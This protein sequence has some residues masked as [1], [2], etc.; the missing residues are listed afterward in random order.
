MKYVPAFVAALA[1]AFLAVVLSL[2]TQAQVQGPIYC[3]SQV[4]TAVVSTATT[5]AILPVPSGSA[6]TYICGFNISTGTVSAMTL[7]F[8]Y[9]TGTACA[10]NPITLGPVI[11]LGSNVFSGDPADIFRGIEVPAGQGLCIV[12]AGTTVAFAAQVF[13]AQQ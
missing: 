12:S 4:T 7:Q 5:T 10:T 6:H 2:P 3:N 8:E 11:S 13:Y 1:L 9:G